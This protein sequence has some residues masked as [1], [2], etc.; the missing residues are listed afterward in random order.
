[1]GKITSQVERL[2][3]AISSCVNILYLAVAY[4]KARDGINKSHLHTWC[5]RNRFRGEYLACL[6]SRLFPPSLSI[7]KYVFI[8]GPTDKQTHQTRQQKREQKTTHTSKD[9][10]YPCKAS[11]HE[12][13]YKQIASKQIIQCSEEKIPDPTQSLMS[14]FDFY[15]VFSLRSAVVSQSSSSNARIIRFAIR[16]SRP[17][18]QR[19]ADVCFIS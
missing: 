2:L 10:V 18:H 5:V 12:R 13:A 17:S 8:C 3:A 19:T 15:F 16:L 6:L 1:M 7:N 9:Q 14:H 4:A 11:Q